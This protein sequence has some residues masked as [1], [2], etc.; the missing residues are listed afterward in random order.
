MVLN[1]GR[2]QVLSESTGVSGPAGRAAQMVKGLVVVDAVTD[3][4]VVGDPRKR[5]SPVPPPAFK[6][7]GTRYYG[8]E[9][10]GYDDDGWD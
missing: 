3:R 6:Y 5:V 8:E 1:E 7:F 4:D 2:G 9:T 10:D